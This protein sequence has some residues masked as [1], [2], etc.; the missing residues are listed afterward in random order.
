MGNYIEDALSTLNIKTETF[1]SVEE[2]I[3]KG[4]EK[5]KYT[6]V[7]GVGPSAD[8]IEYTIVEI[9]GK[10]VKVSIWRHKHTSKLGNLPFEMIFDRKTGRHR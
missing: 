7:I 2:F 10:D 5:K 9:R 6:E 8:V 4:K 3:R 1:S